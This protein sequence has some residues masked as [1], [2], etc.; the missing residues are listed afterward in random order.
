MKGM[1]DMKKTAHPIFFTSLMLF[2]VSAVTLVPLLGATTGSQGPTPTGGQ[3]RDVLFVLQRNERLDV[4]DAATLEPLGFFKT[5]P[6][7]DAIAV[8][9]IIAL[10]RSVLAFG[11]PAFDAYTL[12][13]SGVSRLNFSRMRASPDGR[14]LAVQGRWQT[15]QPRSTQVELFDDALEATGNFTPPQGADL[16]DW[17][18][19]DL[20]VGDISSSD[21]RFWKVASPSL[22]TG[23][24]LHVPRPTALG[25]S[26]GVR[27]V[28]TRFALYEVFGQGLVNALD[29]L[30]APPS[31]GFLVDPT[32]GVVTR[33]APDFYFRDLV[34]TPG[35]E[36][37]YG[38][39][40]W[41]RRRT[42]PLVR[43]DSRTG[44]ILT[45]RSLTPN[46]GTLVNEWN[47]AYAKIPVALLPTGETSVVGCRS[48]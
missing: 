15:P 4:F 35:G 41:P 30:N 38:V 12:N 29:H 28:G 33:I 24:P 44:L 40:D 11:V 13:R 23:A 22:T 10:S 45:E 47:L 25:Q 3:T 1:K 36:V 32:T 7:G 37:L 14:R 8:R 21:M 48:R 27:A 31:G 20:Y 34:S 26:V 46:P 18:G 9:P 16:L 5:G 2:I 6:L 39:E 43:I 42:I 17:I 19:D